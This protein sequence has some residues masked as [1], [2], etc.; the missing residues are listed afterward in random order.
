M[1]NNLH[2]KCQTSSHRAPCFTWHWKNKSTF[3]FQTARKNLSGWIW[4]FRC[5]FCCDL[6][7]ENGTLH[8]IHSQCL[9]FPSLSV[10]HADCWR[11]GQI[12][13][14]TKVRRPPRTGIL[15]RLQSQTVWIHSNSARLAH[16]N[17]LVLGFNRNDW[18]NATWIGLKFSSLSDWHSC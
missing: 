7:L 4:G 18:R 15:K 5:C 11:S 14:G 8:Y 16:E 6:R 3:S 9:F 17:I 12:Y 2:Y 13:T 10:P 1:T